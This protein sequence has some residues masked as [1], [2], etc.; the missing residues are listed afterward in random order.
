M[1]ELLSLFFFFCFV[2]WLCRVQLPQQFCWNGK[3]V[4]KMQQRLPPRAHKLM[5]ALSVHQRHCFFILKPIQSQNLS[6]IFQHNFCCCCCFSPLFP[7]RILPQVWDCWKWRKSHFY[8][9]IF[10]CVSVTRQKV[11]QAYN[12]QHNFPPQPSNT[13]LAPGRFVNACWCC[14]P[15]KHIFWDGYIFLK[16]LWQILGSDINPLPRAQSAV[17]KSEFSR[18]FCSLWICLRTGH[19]HDSSSFLLK[20]H[21]HTLIFCNDHMHS[22]SVMHNDQ[23]ASKLKVLVSSNSSFLA[24]IPRW[25]KIY[26][27]NHPKGS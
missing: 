22:F 24:R 4:H 17:I 13:G 7:S 8:F 10:N 9:L 21:I 12:T 23:T 19:E 16:D 1:Q 3:T 2:Y 26:Q 6:Y 5:I 14:W 11:L 25:M 15:V 18:W 27:Q 20:T